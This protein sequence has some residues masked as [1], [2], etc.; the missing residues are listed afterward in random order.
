MLREDSQETSASIRN[1]HIAAI[2]GLVSPSFA[3]MAMSI[4]ANIANR[5]LYLGPTSILAITIGRVKTSV[6]LPLAKY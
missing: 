6:L 2:L 4:D 5:K 1:P 3:K